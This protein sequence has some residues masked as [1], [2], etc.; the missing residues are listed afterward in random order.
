IRNLTAINDRVTEVRSGYEKIADTRSAEITKVGENL[1]STSLNNK[2]I[3][4][5][6]SIVLTIAGI[7]IAII[8]ASKISKPITIVSKRM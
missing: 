8:T 7:L 1:V 5:I 6:V 2:T 3:G 4:L